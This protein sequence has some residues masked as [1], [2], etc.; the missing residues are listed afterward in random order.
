MRHWPSACLI[1]ILGLTTVGCQFPRDPEGT[2]ER[3]RGDTLRVGV[4]ADPPWV[5]LSKAPPTGVEADLVREFAR[6]I[7]AD[8]EWVESPESELFDAL[9][10]FQLDLIIGGLTTATPYASEAAITRPYVDTEVEIGIPAGHDLP[11]DLGGTEIW[12]ERN[13]AAAAL[14][15]QEEE[16]AIPLVYDHLDQVDGAALLHSWEIE[17]LGYEST[18]YILRDDEHA[19][20]APAGENAFLVELEDFLLDRRQ[21]AERLLVDEARHRHKAAAE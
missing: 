4:L 7:D 15:K 12:V 13:S 9:R 14:L 1:A 3:V 8:V 6:S 17:A 21:R 2:L 10:G 5:D 16:D 19:F 18:D 20:A 11:D